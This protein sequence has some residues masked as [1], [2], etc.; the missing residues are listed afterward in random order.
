MLKYV[1]V[2]GSVI[3]KV[4]VDIVCDKGQTWLKVVA[5]NPRALDLNSQGQSQFGQK[6]ILDQVRFNSG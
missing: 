3:K 4:V 6:S 2:D 5:K 1:S